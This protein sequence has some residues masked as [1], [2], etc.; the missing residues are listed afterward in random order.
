MFKPGDKVVCVSNKL[1]H[2]II[3]LPLNVIFTVD[4]V[5]TFN[6]IT[7]MESNIIPFDSNRFVSLKEYRKLKLEK[8]CLNQEIK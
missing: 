2:D 4:S 3:K 6:D 1:V 7:L 5:L 8:L